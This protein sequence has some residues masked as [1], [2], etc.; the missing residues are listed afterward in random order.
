[1]VIV[2]LGMNEGEFPKVDSRAT[3]DLMGEKFCRGDRSRRADDRYQFLEILLSTRSRLIMT[4]IGRTVSQNEALPPS[5]VIEELLEVMKGGYGIDDLVTVHPLQPFSRRYFSGSP[6]LFSYSRMDFETAAALSSPESKPDSVWWQGAVELSSL[7]TVELSD[8]LAFFHHPQRFFVERQLNVRLAGAER[9]AEEREPFRLEGL[10]E[11]RISQDWIAERLDGR[12]VSAD[13]LR[14]AGIWPSGAAGEILFDRKSGEMEAFV[15]TIRGKSMGEK[16]PDATVD[17]RVGGFRLLGKLT[18]LY[19]RGGLFYRY[20]DLKGRDFM[21]VWLHHLVAN[22]IGPQDTCLICRDADLRLAPDAAR[23]EA[24]P[25]LLEIYRRGLEEPSDFFVEP[26]FEYVRQAL[27]MAGSN[28]VRS[29]PLDKAGGRLKIQLESGFEAEMR[30]LFR[31]VEDPAALLGERF[32]SYCR[33][34][35]L[36]AWEAV[37]GH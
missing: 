31:N 30:L 26:A 37:D 22:R 27:K 8:L 18:N 13:K 35:L 25:E 17:F 32:E 28:R 9:A 34:L 36:P 1:Q 33:D 14:A 29:D 16:L 5:V 11:Y 7:E 2:L 6:P 10:D 23:P 24:L 3:F 21:R 4:F 15:D 20:A 12:S 19:R